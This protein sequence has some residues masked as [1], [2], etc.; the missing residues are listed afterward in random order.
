[1]NEEYWQNDDI[2]DIE[3][4]V[5]ADIRFLR[6]LESLNAEKILSCWSTWN[7]TT[8][9]FPGVDVARGWDSINEAWGT[10]SANTRH[11][12]ILLKPISIIRL[13]DFG[14]TFLSGS[15]ISTHG[16]ETLTV[17]VYMTNVYRRE[18][19]GWKLI[20]HH[21]SPAPHQPSYLEQRLN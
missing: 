7:G 4:I 9:L 12:N 5:E 21:T 8:L 20:H 13:G 16:D 11:L 19:D 14:F 10:V 18:E 2:E 3:P 6:A 1:M 17:E 15:I